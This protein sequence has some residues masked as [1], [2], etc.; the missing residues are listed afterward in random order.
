MSH[1]M[2]ANVKTI[3]HAMVKEHAANGD[4]AQ[5]LQELLTS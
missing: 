5:A 4:G 1:P 2:A 3:V